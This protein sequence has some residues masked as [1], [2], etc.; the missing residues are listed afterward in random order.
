[1]CN[2]LPL[3]S[4]TQATCRCHGDTQLSSVPVVH[5]EYYIHSVIRCGMWTGWGRCSWILH[6][7][8]RPHLAEG[9]K[10][11]KKMDRLANKS[12]T[13]D[14]HSLRSEVD[15]PRRLQRYPATLK[16]TWIPRV[17]HLFFRQ[18]CVLQGT[19]WSPGGAAEWALLPVRCSLG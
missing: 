13:S 14:M 2:L 7:L 9:V 10:K 8:K 6:E 1:M 4:P 18:R 12:N 3:P 16:S 15:V 17:K 11:K 5:L 19:R